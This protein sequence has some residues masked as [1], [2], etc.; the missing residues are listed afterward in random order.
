MSCVTCCP[1]IHGLTTQLCK[2]NMTC[3]CIGGL[4]FSLKEIGISLTVAGVLMLPMTMCAFP[5]VR[6]CTI[7]FIIHTL[8]LCTVGEE[9][10]LHQDILCRRNIADLSAA[11]GPKHSLPHLHSNVRTCAYFTINY[12]YSIL[13]V[14]VKQSVNY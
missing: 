10:G 6:Y 5:L 11:D 12:L 2:Y 8:F 13:V 3:T 1:D 9:S 7:I 4:G 14:F